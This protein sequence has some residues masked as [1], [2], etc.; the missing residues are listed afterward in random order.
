MA[1]VTA[2][3]R[4]AFSEQRPGVQAKFISTIFLLISWRSCKN[5]P[6]SG[7]P[8]SSSPF[9]PP[10][11]S[12][13]TRPD[14][15]LQ[16][17]QH[18]T[19]AARISAGFRALVAGI[20]LAFHRS[21][22]WESGD[23]VIV[24]SEGWRVLQKTS[25]AECEAIDVASEDRAGMKRTFLLPFDIATRLPPRRPAAVTA[26]RWCQAVAAAV[27]ES[28]P[29]GGLRFCPSSIRLLPYQL[30]PALAIFRHGATRLLIADEAGL[31]K[32]VEA[33]SVSYTHLTLPTIL[34]V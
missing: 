33:G 31:G 25:F 12:C 10:I 21:M 6:A 4:R 22:R 27:A 3:L 5:S 20:P 8:V 14:V 29:F 32:T 34:R 30:E 9:T 13:V 28:F 1:S 11:S 17:L 18:A 26:R 23:R 24:R 2:Q 19:Q 16:V 15:A 7:S